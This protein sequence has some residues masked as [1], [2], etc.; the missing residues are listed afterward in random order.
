[1]TK[2]LIIP[3]GSASQL[4][5]SFEMAIAKLIA[6]A[7]DVDKTNGPMWNPLEKPTASAP[8]DATDTRMPYIPND[9]RQ[10]MY[11][12]KQK[13]FITKSTLL[14][15]LHRIRAMREN[16]RELDPFTFMAQKL[17]RGCLIPG[18]EPYL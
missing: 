5:V 7:I 9:R 17:K 4:G 2:A 15:T 18:P 1:M 16:G 11:I 10:N 12:R 13:L 3:A 8:A 6:N 14:K